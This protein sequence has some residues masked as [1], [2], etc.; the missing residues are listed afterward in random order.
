M[1]EYVGC[2]RPV[3]RE[4]VLDVRVQC[5]KEA[6]IEAFT[7][8]GKATFETIYP[9]TYRV[10]VP[11]QQT[12]KIEAMDGHMI[13]SNRVDVHFVANDGIHYSSPATISLYA[14]PTEVVMPKKNC[15]CVAADNAFVLRLNGKEIARGDNWQQCIETPVQWV[16]GDNTIEVDVH[17]TGGPGGA[18]IEVFGEAKIEPNWKAKYQGQDVPIRK[19]E[20]GQGPWGVGVKNTTGQTSWMWI[21]GPADYASVTFSASVNIDSPSPAPEPEPSPVPSNLDSRV[22]ALESVIAKLKEV[23]K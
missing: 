8:Q 20:Y 2:V 12:Q 18:I 15:I 5:D 4:V 14:P 7:S 19:T 3:D 22:S 13:L 10:T 9:N 21:N 1:P 23:F 6:A 17:N 11:V 16:K